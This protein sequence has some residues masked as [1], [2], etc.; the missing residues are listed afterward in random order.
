[1]EQEEKI[2]AVDIDC[3]QELTQNEEVDLIKT[4]DALHDL[5]WSIFYSFLTPRLI[6]LLEGEP[7]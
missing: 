2:L 6:N 3:I 7:A 1:M 5:V 4:V